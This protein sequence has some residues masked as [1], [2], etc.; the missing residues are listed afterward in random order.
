MS[1]APYPPMVEHPYGF[2]E[3]NPVLWADPLGRDA[4][5][6]SYPGTTSGIFDIAAHHEV[7]FDLYNGN[8]RCF[9]FAPTQ[10]DIITL[11]L[12][13][14]GVPRSETR[15]LCDMLDRM[16]TG[17]F[18]VTQYRGTRMDA[19]RAINAGNT[20]VSTVQTYQLCLSNCQ[21]FAGNLMDIHNNP[22]HNDYSSNDTTTA[23]T[24][25]LQL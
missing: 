21:V 12:P 9:D 20:V 24:I 13:F 17:E 23:L 2:A 7:C 22:A 25:R 15:N 8:A 10:Q 1:T 16:R 3:G 19:I 5:L 14:E 11:L 4:Y 6:I 18:H